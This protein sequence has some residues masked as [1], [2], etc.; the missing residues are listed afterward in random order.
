MPAPKPE[1]RNS[2]VP[3]QPDEPS[4]FSLF[5]IPVRIGLGFWLMTF[6]FGFRSDRP[7]GAG[8]RAAIAWT[9]IVFVS[10]LLHE[11]GH[12]LAARRFGARPSIKLHAFGGLTYTGVHLSRLRQIVISLAGPF[13]GFAFGALIFA[14]SR[15]VGVAPDKLFR[16]RKDPQPAPKRARATVRTRSTNGKHS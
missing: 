5:G 2:L 15:K 10:I 9:A 4:H 16:L 3:E 13:M 7:L 8:L 6:F 14:V 1:S 12:A 11:L